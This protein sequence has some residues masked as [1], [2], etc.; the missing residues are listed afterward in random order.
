MLR[1]V[2]G[3]FALSVVLA[4]GA[5]SAAWA[6]P[7]AVS[8]SRAAVCVPSTRPKDLHDPAVKPIARMLVSS[9]E[10]SSL[11]WEAQYG[12]IEYNVEG[13]SWENR[14]YTAGLVGFTTKNGDLRL[15]VERYSKSAPGNRLERFL[16]A[17]RRVEGTSSR[18][19]LGEAFVSAW[20]ASARDQK[21]L[22]AQRDLADE[23]YYNPAVTQAKADGLGIL[24]QFVYADAAIMHGFGSEANSFEFIRGAAVRRARTPARGGSERAYLK[25][26]LDARIN[27]MRAEAGHS[28]V[29]RVTHAQRRFLSE[30]NL[31]L[32]PPLRWSVY[33][34]PFVIERATTGC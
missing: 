26:F 24:G 3:A 10:N 33:G 12:Y 9:A 13:N 14:G 32:R 21:F 34:D 1:R 17:L 20:R 28:D 8:D 7:P 25:A 11:R 19:G 16:P 23:F 6:R 27:A 30:G 18:R 22:A 4:L 29:S 15:L 2:S 31:D 5:T